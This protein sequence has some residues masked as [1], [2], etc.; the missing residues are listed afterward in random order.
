VAFRAGGEP[1]RSAAER[2]GEDRRADGGVDHHLVAGAMS[3]T[4][5]GN[6][7]GNGHGDVTR[8]D[9]EAAIPVNA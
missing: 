4:T 7:N 1:G 9:V 8:A 3:A 2:A 5:G 6:G